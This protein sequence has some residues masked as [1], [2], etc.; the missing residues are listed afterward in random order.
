ML[1]ALFS[2]FNLNVRS[3]WLLSRP[4]CF[5]TKHL[6]TTYFDLWPINNPIIVNWAIWLTR[7]FVCPKED[8][9]AVSVL[10]R[11]RWVKLRQW[12]NFQL[13][14]FTRKFGISDELIRI[15]LAPWKDKTESLIG[16]QN[17][18]KAIRG[19]PDYLPKQI[20]AGWNCLTVV[21]YWEAIE[22]IFVSQLSNDTL[23]P[24]T[25]LNNDNIDNKPLRF[26]PHRYCL[27]LALRYLYW[28]FTNT[29]CQH[30]S[31][32]FVKHSMTFT[33]CELEERHFA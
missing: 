5:Y 19:Q 18:P 4:L 28:L 24:G 23:S 21:K 14:W 26:S 17:A 31:S 12:L 2:T 10:S 22:C 1:R 13:F 33:C 25:I 29:R 27:Q 9:L 16:F 11:M 8:I 20:N 30:N 32:S 7:V 15:R 3:H 6:A